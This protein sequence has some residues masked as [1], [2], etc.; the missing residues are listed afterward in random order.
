MKIN[1]S[2]DD[3]FGYDYDESNPSNLKAS[4]YDFNDDELDIENEDGPEKNF[5]ISGNET[6][7]NG[8][9]SRRIREKITNYMSDF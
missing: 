9:S 6:V 3:C 8:F 1:F 2:R 4:Q 7:E 5:P